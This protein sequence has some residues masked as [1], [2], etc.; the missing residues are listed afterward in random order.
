MNENKK[1]PSKERPLKIHP[2]YTLKECIEMSFPELTLS[3]KGELLQ[4][5]KKDVFMFI[6]KDESFLTK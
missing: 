6:D 4:R 5:F 3:E 2:D 1:L